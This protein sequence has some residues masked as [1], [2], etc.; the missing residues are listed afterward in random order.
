MTLN[1]TQIHKPTLIAIILALIICLGSPISA[2][3]E[4]STFADLNK[5]FSQA[6][7][8]F[9]VEY[10]EADETEQ[11]A[12]LK[13]TSREPRGRFTPLFLGESRRLQGTELALPG[14]TWLAEH[15]TIA[16]REV[17]DLAVERILEDHLSSPDLGPAAKA[18]RRSAGVRGQQRALADLSLIVEASFFDSV[19]AAALL[20]RGLLLRRSDQPVEA[21]VARADLERAIQLATDDAITTAAS[22]GLA[23]LGVLAIGTK[24]PPLTGITVGGEPIDGSQLEG[25]VVLVEFWGMWCGPCVAKLPKLGRLEARFRDR[26]FTILGINSD[27]D[28]QLVREFLE[29]KGTL[30]PSIADGST[31]GPVATAWHVNAWPAS[32]LIDGE[33]RIQARD[34]S[35]K[36]VLSFLED[37]A[38]SSAGPGDAQSLD[39]ESAKDSR[40]RGSI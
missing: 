36:E 17:G 20:Q 29:A 9:M 7:E 1:A 8:E 18:I 15:G 22:K 10:Q 12:M 35:L 27:S 31:E 25:R 28:S 34:P 30:W 40:A 37:L 21:A 2:T 19:L 4:D 32:Y 39:G 6:V 13:D 3:S 5:R 33:G 14:W 26:P 11:E 24:A 16:D 23:D 38:P